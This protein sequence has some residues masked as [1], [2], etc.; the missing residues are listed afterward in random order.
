[1]SIAS[2]TSRA[3]SVNQLNRLRNYRFIEVLINDSIINVTTYAQYPETEDPPMSESSALTP[4]DGVITS[5]ARSGIVQIRPMN[6]TNTAELVTGQ[7]LAFRSSDQ[8]SEDR[9]LATIIAVNSLTEFTALLDR[10]SLG[11][12]ITIKD[13]KFTKSAPTRSTLE[14]VWRDYRE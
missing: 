12:T 10:V 7:E 8:D 2:L 11:Q 1:M 6:P 9:Y 3:G 13:Q 4:L 14:P 5:E